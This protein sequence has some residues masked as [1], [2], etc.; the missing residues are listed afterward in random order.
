MSNICSTYDMDNKKN[1]TESYVAFCKEWSCN[2]FRGIHMWLSV[3]FL[4][5]LISGGE[6]YVYR[7]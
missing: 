6:L 1:T 2:I 4:I 5:H 7:V 3:G